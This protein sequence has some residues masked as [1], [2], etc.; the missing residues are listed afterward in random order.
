MEYNAAQLPKLLG[1]GSLGDF[2]ERLSR[3]YL[4]DGVSGAFSVACQPFTDLH[5]RMHGFRT[6]LYNNIGAGAETEQAT[7]MLLDIDEVILY[8]EDLEIFALGEGRA[9]FHQSYRQGLLSYQKDDI[10]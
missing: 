8:I 3:Q 4:R 9:A 2:L 1:K 6:E 7:Q 10:Q 5:K